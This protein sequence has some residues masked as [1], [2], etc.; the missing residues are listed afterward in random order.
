MAWLKRLFFITFIGAMCFFIALNVFTGLRIK[1]YTYLFR[2]T[3]PYDLVIKH[4]KIF[5]GSGENEPFRGDIGI[6][7]GYIVGVGYINPKDSPV[8]DAGGLTFLPAPVKIEES[9]GVIA[10]LLAASY[11]RYSADEI[12]LWESPYEGVSLA[13]A[14]LAKGVT[15]AEMFK[16]LHTTA[17]STTKVFLAPLA[18]V[19]DD[20][21]A[22]EML[23]RLTS[24][25]A[26]LMGRQDVGCI[27]EGFKAEMCMIKTNDY[28][29]ETLT[30]F[31]ARG[32]MPP[33][34]YR[35]EGG[36]FVTDQ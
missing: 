4:A 1:G 32:E 36:R 3:T 8:F 21:S 2:A 24:Y 23:A 13:Q 20:F 33:P 28:S 30:H 22:Q 7:D 6:R 16:Y 12:F 31:F 9:D 27:R 25:R 10:H 15:V 14:A 11:P 18:L 19:E 5:D 26:R 17:A 34:V 29:V 35:I